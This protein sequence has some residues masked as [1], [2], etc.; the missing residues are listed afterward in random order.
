MQVGIQQ[1]LDALGSAQLD[2]START[3]LTGLRQAAANLRLPQADW[4]KSSRFDKVEEIIWDGFE[5]AHGLPENFD[6]DTPPDEAYPLA[7]TAP[8]TEITSED[9]APEDDL[10]LEDV[11]AR[12]PAAARRRAAELVRKYRRKIR[13]D[14]DKLERALYLLEAAQSNIEAQT[15]T[16]Q[17]GASAADG[18]TQAAE[19]SASGV[20]VPRMGA[21]AKKAPQAEPGEESERAEDAS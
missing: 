1:V 20:A 14:E 2:R 7:A 15:A 19:S 13:Y 11:L 17:A 16:V 12:D 3:M 21:A 10:G 18:A 6:V 5:E 4:D 8:V 9:A